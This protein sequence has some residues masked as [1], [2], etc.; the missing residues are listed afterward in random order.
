MTGK[1]E[2]PQ[3]AITK[4]GETMPTDIRSEVKT[5]PADVSGEETQV[6]AKVL[7]TLSG[8][9][10]AIVM[11]LIDKISPEIRTI[12]IDFEKQDGRLPTAD[13]IIW[14]IG[15][16]HKLDPRYVDRLLENT[17]DIAA[18]EAVKIAIEEHK[19]KAIFL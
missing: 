3:D 15:E 12:I 18:I 7:R 11:K 5:L 13:E 19:P 1:L 17:I 4:K 8:G 16:H 14:I 9:D 10:N 2:K 6:Q